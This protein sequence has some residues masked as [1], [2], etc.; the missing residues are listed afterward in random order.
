MEETTTPDA[1]RLH[2]LHCPSCG[3][4]V[5][6]APEPE[7]AC[8][9]CGRPVPI[10]EEHLRAAL[11]ARHRDEKNR[12]A[13]ALWRKVSS[14]A[15]PGPLLTLL[16]ILAVI[17]GVSVLFPGLPLMAAAAHRSRY[18]VPFL[19]WFGAVEAI[20]VAYALVVV[21]ATSRGA[22]V[23]ACWGALGGI[24]V[25]GK[26]G[27]YRCRSCGGMLRAEASAIAVSCPYC[28]RDN[29]VGLAPGR[30]A[31]LLGQARHGTLSLEAAATAVRFRRDERW[32][33]FLT[34]FLLG[35]LVLL[36]MLARALDDE[37]ELGWVGPAAAF[38]AALIGLLV[39]GFGV[40]MRK[41]TA[42]LKAARELWQRNDSLAE[43]LLL[44]GDYLLAVMSDAGILLDSPTAKAFV[45]AGSVERAR[46]A[47]LQF[48]VRWRDG[49]RVRQ[50][51]FHSAA[52]AG[53][54]ADC[55]RRTAGEDRVVKVDGDSVSKGR[56]VI[57]ALIG[58]AILGWAAGMFLL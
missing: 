18:V 29:L 52:G 7:V 54:I 36:P 5:P 40:S 24:P 57:N 6:F 41:I 34:Q 25:A 45:P 21:Q 15:V 22:A 38:G 8:V 2:D 50:K 1:P 16:G 10:P 23:A 30:L 12:A 28:G 58:L 47:G 35:Q 4:K 14:G 43:V 27:L 56:A 42:H 55:L 3:G 53:P 20:L 51:S 11:A 9:H 37:L 44:E 46:F 49:D 33:Y 31:S 13:A 26:P 17:A 48:D 39:F 19:I 32:L